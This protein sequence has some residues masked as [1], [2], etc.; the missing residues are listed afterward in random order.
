[1]NT[2]VSLLLLFTYNTLNQDNNYYLA[3]YLLKHFYEIEDISANTLAKNCHTSITS[4]N[5]FCQKLG[6][7]TFKKM[8][9]MLI[10]TKNGRYEQIKHRYRQIDIDQSFELLAKIYHDDLDIK[11]LAKEIDKITS[12]IHQSNKIICFGAVFPLSL[13]ANFIEDMLM[14]DKYIEIRQLGYENNLENYG[15]DCLL[16][17]ITITGRFLTMNKQFFLQLSHTNAKKIIVSQKDFYASYDILLKLKGKD[18]EEIENLV[19]LELFNLIKYYYY[20]K[21]IK[22]DNLT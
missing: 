1:M 15:E 16:F 18:D 6:F 14:F 9:T 7:K 17:F 12:L 4:V 11:L 19:I 2:V 20:F 5:N 13:L 22:T 8:K 10:N 3:K 21:Y